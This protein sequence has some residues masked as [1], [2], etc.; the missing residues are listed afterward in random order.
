MK[1][2]ILPALALASCLTVNVHAQ[3]VAA[4]L[5]ALMNK[6]TSNVIAQLEAEEIA[7]AKQGKKAS[8]TVNNI[9][10]RQEL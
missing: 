10:I 5:N 8:C 4:Q 3:D 9:A 6:A 2:S 7:L 1:L